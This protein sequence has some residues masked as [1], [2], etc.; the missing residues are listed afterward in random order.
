[1]W[2]KDRPLCFDYDQISKKYGIILDSDTDIN[3]DN[4]E[5]KEKNRNATIVE[6]GKREEALP[7][8]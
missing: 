5:H 3:E 8:E 4:Y 7:F 6:T 1:V 2:H